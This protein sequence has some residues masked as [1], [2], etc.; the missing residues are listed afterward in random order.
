MERCGLNKRENEIEVPQHEDNLEYL[1]HGLSYGYSGTEESASLRE[2]IQQDLGE[3]VRALPAIPV[4]QTQLVRDSGA[5]DRGRIRILAK[6]YLRKW[7][8]QAIKHVAKYAELEA[9]AAQRDRYTLQ[10]QALDS[11]LAAHRRVQQ[12]EGIKRH[13]NALERRAAEVYDGF[14]K[15]KAFRHWYSTTLEAEAKTEA[16]RQKYLYVKY[17]NAWHQLTVTNELKA[18]RQNLKAHY[19]LLRKRAAQYYLD[20]VNALELYCSNLTKIIFW[21]WA[22]AYAGR[23]ARKSRD[24]ELIKRT[25]LWWRAKL[26]DREEQEHEATLLYECSTLLNTL[27]LWSTHTSVDRARNQQADA[28]CRQSLM[29]RTLLQWKLATQLTPLEGQVAR[30]RDWRIARSNF[31]GWLLRV[32]MIFRADWVNTLRTK[33]NAFTLWNERLRREVVQTRIDDRILA[34]AMYK[35]VIAQRAFLMIRIGRERM[36]RAMFGKLLAGSRKHTHML[37]CQEVQVETRRFA[38]LARSTLGCWKLQMNHNTARS[39]MAVEFHMPKIQQDILTTWRHQHEHVQKLEKWATDANFYFFMVKSLRR[40]RDAASE[41]KKRRTNDAYKK[42]RR[43]VKMNL[44]RKVLVRWRNRLDEI[45]SLD[46]RCERLRRSNDADLLRGLILH[47]HGRD[48]QREQAM[49]D[50]AAQHDRRLLTNS[51]QA[52]IKASSQATNLQIRAVQFYHI[53]LSELCSA[54][55]RRLS[56][57]AFGIKRRQQDAAAMRER[58]WAKHVRSILRH[59]ATRSGDTTYQALVQGSSEPT[60]AGYGTASQDDPPAISTGGAMGPGAPGSTQREVDWTACEADLLDNDDWLPPSDAHEPA[61]VISTAMATPGY[62]NTPSKRAAR[63][64]AWAKMS[65]T[66]ATP[67][68]TPFAARLRTGVAG[69]PLLFAGS[70]LHTAR[71]GSIGQSGLGLNVHTAKRDQADIG[72]RDR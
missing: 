6:K 14:L 38:R 35:W 26:K 43:Q 39:Q 62:L 54:N 7:L 22:F 2:E 68:T 30:T 67:L 66:P 41:A 46:E 20:E 12:E 24:T 45:E 19:Q 5:F 58:H 9:D 47:W 11:W 15:A 49:A 34:Q 57:K 28:F 33:Q 23:K 42:M 40:W 61:P 27:Q 48:V 44:A 25:L 70:A 4:S 3:R 31:S 63:A 21:R 1:A 10:R 37:H 55:L 51:R 8:S 29:R 13:F 65:T 36:K 53:H 60:D 59:W 17:F 32:R 16:A 56:M 50:A 71:K 64:K 72:Y 69:S 52:W 18:E